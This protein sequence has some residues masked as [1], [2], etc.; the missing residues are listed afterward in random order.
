MAT[1]SL[2][3]SLQNKLVSRIERRELTCEQLMFY[4]KHPDASM[5]SDAVEILGCQRESKA[6]ALMYP[7]LKDPER[8]VRI[9]VAI[10]LIRMGEGDMLQDLMASLHHPDRQVVIG[11]ALTLGRLEDGRAS[12]E[13]VKAFVTDDPEVGAAVAWALGQCKNVLALP[14]LISAIKHHF[15]PA[16]AC[17]ALGKIGD[18]RALDILLDAVTF[19]DEDVRAYAARAL[20]LLKFQRH[21]GQNETVVMALRSLLQDGSRKV[22]MC[23]AISLYQLNHHLEKHGTKTDEAN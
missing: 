12:I 21:P 19:Q 5:R 10:A 16:N 8:Q 22:R 11:A 7:L 4:L 13:L 9:Q 20:S 14:F 3:I 2:N 23:A 15:V 17:E 6:I 18:E 1:F